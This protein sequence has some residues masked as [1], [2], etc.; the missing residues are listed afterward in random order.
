MVAGEHMYVNTLLNQLANLLA[1]R[2]VLVLALVV[3]VILHP[4]I[5]HVAQHVDG[6]GIFAHLFQHIDQL[7]LVR[8]SPLYR[9]TP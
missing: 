2:M 7:L 9:Q 4:E 6:D 5:E 8:V 3:D 1:E